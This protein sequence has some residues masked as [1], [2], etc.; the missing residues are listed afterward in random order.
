MSLWAL[1][2]SPF[3]LGAD[4]TELD[5]TDV[6][7]LENRAVIGVDQDGI[8]ARRIVHGITRQVFAKTERGREVVVGLFTPAGYP[9]RFRLRLMRWDC[10]VQ[11]SM[12]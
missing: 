12:K 10:P 7:Y 6:S 8:D 9:K 4:L 5:P 3:I 1:A 11:T 2:A